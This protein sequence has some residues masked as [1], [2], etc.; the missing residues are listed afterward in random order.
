MQI[1]NGSGKYAIHLSKHVI[2]LLTSDTEC[3]TRNDMD[4]QITFMKN[5]NCVFF[6]SIQLNSK[7]RKRGRKCCMINCIYK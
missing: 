1:M 4:L 6:S 2:V 7:I 3:Q 5:D